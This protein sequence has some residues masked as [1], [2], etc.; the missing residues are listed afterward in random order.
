MARCRRSSSS[1][2]FLW[3]IIHL[4][5]VSGNTIQL[6][7]TRRGATIDNQSKGLSRKR[8]LSSSGKG[9]KK[10]NFWYRGFYS[11][12]TESSPS[13]Q[14]SQS[15]SRSGS[16]GRCFS[17][18]VLT[19]AVDRNLNLFCAHIEDIQIQVL[20]PDKPDG[21]DGKF[22]RSASDPCLVSHQT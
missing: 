11:H 10:S 6:D 18:Q 22:P 13:S 1:L 3:M 20:F 7:N 8:R 9:S 19:I 15:S 17:G 12:S 5:L 21:H 4:S 14:S 16:Y 2:S